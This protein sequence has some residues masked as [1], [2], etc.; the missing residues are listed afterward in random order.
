VSYGFLALGFASFYH[1]TGMG[2]VVSSTWVGY[3]AIPD[4][5]VEYKVPTIM[6]EVLEEYVAKRSPISKQSTGRITLV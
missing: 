5:Q 3:L 4:E 6:P 1:P 2:L